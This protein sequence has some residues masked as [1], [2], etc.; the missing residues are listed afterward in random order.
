MLEDILFGSLALPGELIRVV[1]AVAGTAVAAYFDIT[2]KKNVPDAFL[3]AFLLIAFVVNAVF[4]EET[5]FW[6]SMA[7]AAFVAA[8]GYLFYRAGQF[9]GAD[10]FVLAAVMLLIPVHP[11]FSDMPFNLP[12]GF[13]VF[14]FSGVIFA[15][16]VMAY[17]GWKLTQVEAKPNL[18][19]GL[20]LIPYLAF[21]WFFINSFLFSPVFFAIVTVAFFASIFFLMF[22]DSLNMLLAEELPVSQLE[23]EDVL[24]LE[25]MNRD[26]VERY[27][28]PRLMTREEISRLKKSKVKEVWVYTKLPPFLPFMLAGVLLSLFF[29][30][31]LLLI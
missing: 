6:F 24:A 2:N 10:V 20:M 28:I 12:F 19:Y 26:L 29:A 30:K 5:L 14:V 7:A 31:Y 18:L 22:R 8:V 1:L 9:G 4:Y 3:Y 16:F 11:S 17:F 13:S 25:V 15:V 27:K 23:P 21:A